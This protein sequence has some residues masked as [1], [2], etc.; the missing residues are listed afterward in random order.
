MSKPPAY[1][2]PKNRPPGVR[3]PNS[4]S[5]TEALATARPVGDIHSDAALFP[6]PKLLWAHL[7][8]ISVRIVARSLS[9]YSSC[10]CDVSC[11][12]HCMSL[13]S[14]GNVHPDQLRASSAG[15]WCCDW[16]WDWDDW[17]AH[18]WR[19]ARW[20]VRWLGSAWTDP[21][22]SWYHTVTASG[23]SQLLPLTSHLSWA[24]CDH[25]VVLWSKMF[26]FHQVKTLENIACFIASE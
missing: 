4:N 2:T 3:T 18:K 19:R 22:D 24:H 7:L 25:L 12:N 20:L 8:L 9:N 23:I 26:M 17:K 1:H 16:S 5:L 14:A 13:W 10:E 6:V 15:A 21:V 11:Y